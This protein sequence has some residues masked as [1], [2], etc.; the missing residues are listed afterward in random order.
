M[1]AAK[2]AT[3]AIAVRDGGFGEPNGEPIEPGAR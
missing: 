3:I 2:L 1:I